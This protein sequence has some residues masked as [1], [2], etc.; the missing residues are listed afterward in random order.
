ME[1]SNLK[2]P[3][4][5]IVSEPRSGSNNLSY[6]LN[7]HPDLEVGNELF[8]PKNGVDVLDFKL[9]K[10]DI[11]L[12]RSEKEGMHWINSIC[13]EGKWKVCDKLFEKF[14]GFKIHTEHVNCEV[15]TE[16]IKR[17]DCFVIFTYRHNVFDQF[18]SNC[19][20]S[21]RGIWHADENKMPNRSYGE[22]VTQNQFVAWV[23]NLYQLRNSIWNG[24][25]KATT[26]V[27]LSEYE[28]FY[29]G[30]HEEKVW[31]I[32]V[33]LDFMKVKRFGDLM[34]TEKVV[35]YDK[36]TRFLSPSK[37]KM[38]N[39]VLI[40]EYIPNYDALKRRYEEWRVNSFGSIVG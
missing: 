35:S 18:V 27:M 36:L 32:L 31:R 29:S 9:G 3:K 2:T 38:T 13:D 19:I 11:N 5:L 20:A 10:S 17:Y 34:E 30:S 39:R 12:A 6:V 37:Q 28:Q 21:R 40:D 25:G 8:H 14:N 26:R 24:V 33:M 1:F 16:I 4:F 22:L 15:L 23:E 7:A